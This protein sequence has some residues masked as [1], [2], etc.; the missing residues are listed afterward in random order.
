V[1][2]LIINADDFGLTAG[3]NRAILECHRCG[4]VTS[5]T[6]MANSCALN[7]AILL[8][9][10][11]PELS[12]GCHVVLVDGSPVLDANQVPSLIHSRDGASDKGH[13]H[14][15]FAGLVRRA[16]LG[17]LV[18][19]QIE[20]EVTAQIRKLQASG[21][22][23]SHLDTHKHTHMIPQVLGPLLRAAKACG[24]RRIRNPFEPA[25]LSLVGQHAG[26]WKRFAQVKML[27]RLA[28][29]FHRAVHGAGIVTPDGTFGIV[30]TGWLDERLFKFLIQHLTDGTW[31]LV[32]HPGYN[33]ADLRAISTRLRESRER[34]LRLLGSSEARTFLANYGIEL[35]SYDQFG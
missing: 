15:G 25:R 8:A 16:V 19:E 30:S 21:I 23:V 7:D 1:R 5:T 9:Q 24:V 22:A 28:K 18:P 27:G 6:L 12:V 17:R 29:K 20:A 34:E 3:V 26:M 35:I 2:R 31:E 33:D 10:S 11:A 14:R 4:A 13:F 32:C